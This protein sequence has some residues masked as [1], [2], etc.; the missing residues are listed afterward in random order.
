MN[1]ESFR[2]SQRFFAGRAGD[3]YTKRKEEVQIDDERCIWEDTCGCIGRNKLASGIAMLWLDIFSQAVELTEERWQH[4]VT[5]HPIMVTYR[6]KIPTTLLDPDYIKR[7]KR[8]E[9]VTLYYRYFADILDGKY[10]LSVVKKGLP[11][12]FILTGYVTRSVMKGETLW[13]RS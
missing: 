10:L 6:D 11:R 1:S 3:F 2:F 8:D 13:E 4:I 12:S 9:H 7:S 5:E